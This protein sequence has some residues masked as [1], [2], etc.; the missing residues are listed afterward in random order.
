MTLCPLQEKHPAASHQLD[1]LWVVATIL[2]ER[3]AAADVQ[4][5]HYLGDANGYRFLLLHGLN[6]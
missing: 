5:T 1:A 4:K 2:A 3:R 6:C